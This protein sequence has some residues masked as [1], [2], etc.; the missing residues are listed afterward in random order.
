M[1]FSLP[2]GDVRKPRPLGAEKI[3]P[4]RRDMQDT[5][6]GRSGLRIDLWG[7]TGLS[8]TIAP[9]FPANIHRPRIAPFESRSAS[10]YP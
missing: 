10:E 4:G 1:F 8:E 5:L 6:A 2:F 9:C 7:S 3:H